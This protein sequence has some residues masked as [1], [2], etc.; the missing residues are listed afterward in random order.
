MSIYCS[1]YTFMYRCIGVHNIYIYILF[2]NSICSI[3]SQYGIE[4]ACL[5]NLLTYNRAGTPVVL[6][7]ELD[8]THEYRIEAKHHFAFLLNRNDYIC[9]FQMKR[10]LTSPRFSRHRR[11][12]YNIENGGQ[13]WPPRECTKEK[14]KM[15]VLQP[16]FFFSQVHVSILE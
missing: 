4:Q 16:I 12:A 7:I 10:S 3:Q 9:R 2:R 5:C 14:K 8:L 11:R 1:I 15:K 13:R 6:T